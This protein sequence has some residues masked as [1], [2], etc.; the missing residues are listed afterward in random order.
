MNHFA[1]VSLALVM[2]IFLGSAAHATDVT[3]FDWKMRQIRNQLAAVM[4]QT[5]RAREDADKGM[6]LA[7][8]RSSPLLHA[9]AE[10]W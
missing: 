2:L 1:L 4:E 3:S 5:K 9:M 10:R 7:R 8:M 6:T